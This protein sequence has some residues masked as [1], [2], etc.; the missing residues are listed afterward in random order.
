MACDSEDT[1]TKTQTAEGDLMPG[2]QNYLDVSS[3]S[4][5]KPRPERLEGLTQP[6][7]C[8]LSVWPRLPHSKAALG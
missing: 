8:G 2:C 5:W 3:L 4:Q 1:V 7:A 6:P